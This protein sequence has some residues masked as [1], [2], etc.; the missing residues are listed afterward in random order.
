MAGNSISGTAST[1][2]DQDPSEEVLDDIYE[3]VENVEASLLC[4]LECGENPSV[5]LVSNMYNLS[6]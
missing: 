6:V 1:I 4:T 3:L 2:I 5:I